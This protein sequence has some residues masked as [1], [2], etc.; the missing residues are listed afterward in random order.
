MKSSNSFFRQASHF[1]TMIWAFFT[2]GEKIY[3]SSFLGLKFRLNLKYLVDFLIYYNGSFQQE[4]VS[5]IKKVISAYHID[6]FVDIGSHIGQM[7]LF[8]SKS[9]P[10]IEVISIEPSPSTRAR[11]KH[12]MALNNLDYKLLPYAMGEN[13]GKARI[14]RPA[15]VYYKEYFKYNDG[16]FS[17]IPSHD[18]TPDTRLD[19]QV[20]TLDNLLGGIEKSKR[21]LIKIDVE[22]FELE[23][24]K[25]GLN[26]L[27]SHQ[28]ILI[29]ELAVLVN[30][31]KCE[32]V[33][34]LLKEYHFKMYNLQLEEIE[35]VK[36]NQNTDALFI[37]F[38]Q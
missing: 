34:D 29:L 21:V 9:F 17:L 27:S 23:V 30:P 13:E 11:Q 8:V 28:I 7:S 3:H 25:G 37:N 32:Q 2:R 36:T 6:L 38:A 10:D 15:K 20:S 16:R 14:Y 22:G 26:L 35:E 4:V 19:I 18:T 24:L 5:S 33:I 31:S 1:K 12:N